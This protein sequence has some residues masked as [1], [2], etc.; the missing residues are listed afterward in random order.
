MTDIIEI[1]DSV[2]QLFAQGENN[3]RIISYEKEMD[4]IQSMQHFLELIGATEW[5]IVEDLGTQVT[6]RHMDYPQH[7]VINAGGLGDFFSHGFD[8]TEYNFG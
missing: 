4:N 2:E 6:V 3:Y 7:M 5:N 1:P 8:V